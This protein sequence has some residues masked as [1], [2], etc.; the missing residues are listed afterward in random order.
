MRKFHYFLMGLAA[1]AL[2]GILLIPSA[3]ARADCQPDPGTAG[4]DVITCTGTDNDGVNAGGGNDTITVVDT[5]TVNGIIDGGDGND[6]INNSGTT[7]VIE[8]G[9][10][11][12]VINNPGA[13]VSVYGDAG[14]DV[15]NNSGTVSGSIFGWTGNDVINNSGT[16][17]IIYGEGGNDTVRL[18]NGASGLGGTLSLYGGSDTDT[19][20]FDFTVTDPAEEQNLHSTIA[21]ASPASGNLTFRGTLFQ[22]WGFEALVDLVRRALAPAGE[23]D[24][25]PI[26]DG[27]NLA[28]CRYPNGDVTFLR[29]KDG[30]GHP[31][32]FLSAEEVN[33]TPAGGVALDH[34]D[35][36]G[37]RLRVTRTEEGDFLIELFA[38]GAGLEEEGTLEQVGPEALPVATYRLPL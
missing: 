5:G 23:P 30:E 7:T 34:T 1:I 16:A 2:L 11:D 22:W 6:V 36:E 38:P 21:A 20:I 37:Y 25:C 33:A 4:D 12:D 31:H 29:L 28:V 19:L 8:A 13:A 26:N 32:S 3:S 35:E 15:I 18:Q 14:N 10:G 17:A 24:P 27:V 9:T